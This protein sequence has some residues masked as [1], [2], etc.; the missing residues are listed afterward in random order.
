MLH[1]LEMVADLLTWKISKYGMKGAF[2]AFNKSK[3]TSYS[4]PRLSADQPLTV[5]GSIPEEML[6]WL[7][8][9]IGNGFP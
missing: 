1:I 7:G 3:R 9:L 8:Q 2:F 5:A 6:E 4:L